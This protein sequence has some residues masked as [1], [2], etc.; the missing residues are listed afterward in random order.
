MVSVQFQPEQT[1]ETHDMSVW[2]ESTENKR[3]SLVILRRDD[4]ASAFG[5]RSANNRNSQ[6]QTPYLNLSGQVRAR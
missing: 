6:L 2:F 3:N 1:A 4:A 5:G